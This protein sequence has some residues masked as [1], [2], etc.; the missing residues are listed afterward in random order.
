MLLISIKSKQAVAKKASLYK[1]KCLHA[2]KLPH[3]GSAE[4]W[5]SFQIQSKLHLNYCYCF[6]TSW[7]KGTLSIFWFLFPSLLWHLVANSFQIDCLESRS[8][9]PVIY[10][11]L[12]DQSRGRSQSRQHL[13]GL[14]PKP[15]FPHCNFLYPHIMVPPPPNKCAPAVVAGK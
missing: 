14:I 5:P 12:Y 10:P 1:S 9:E 11:H 6:G 2:V 7:K 15:L 8:T 3:I 4:Y 13:V